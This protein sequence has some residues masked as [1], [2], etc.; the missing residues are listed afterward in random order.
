MCLWAWLIP[1]E[2][3]LLALDVLRLPVEE[4]V[5]EAAPPPRELFLLL[6]VVGVSAG[7]RLHLCGCRVTGVVR[8][9]SRSERV[10]IASA[11]AGSM[12]VWSHANQFLGL[13]LGPSVTGRCVT[14]SGTAVSTGRNGFVSDAGNTGGKRGGFEEI[15]SIEGVRV[16]DVS[17]MGGP[18]L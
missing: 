12:R 9:D 5:L 15:G 2:D 4:G 11:D 3:G 10:P 13:G 1:L 16:S 17:G 6:L 18:G 8:G 7:A 14:G